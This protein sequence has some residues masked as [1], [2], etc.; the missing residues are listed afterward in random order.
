MNDDTQRVN[1][2]RLRAI[3]LEAKP[4][5]PPLPPRF[6]QSVWRRIEKEEAAP[7]PPP[8]LYALLVRWADRL[9][10]PRFA[11]ASLT[12]LLLAGGLTGFVSSADAVKQRA[13]ERYLSSVAPNIL[14]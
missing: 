1:D 8:S 11:L 14:R 2:E 9:F 4:A 5:A 3:L 7:I 13:Q 10:L 6:Q 12:L